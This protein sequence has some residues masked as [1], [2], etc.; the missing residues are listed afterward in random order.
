MAQVAIIGAGMSG[1][2][3][4]KAL[5]DKGF[6]NFTIFD[7]KQPNK[8]PKKGLHYL[9]NPC[10]LPLKAE[11]VHNIVIGAN[12]T[13][14]PY[15]QYANKLRIPH[16]NSVNG[17]KSYTRVYDFN[18]AYGMLLDLFRERIRVEEM[19]RDSVRRLLKYGEYD[20]AVSTIPRDCV[21]SKAQC[22]G[23]EVLT[24]TGR[25]VNWDGE[26]FPQL[27]N[28]VIYNLDEKVSWYRYSRVFGHEV[29]EYGRRPE[30]VADN[31]PTITKIIKDEQGDVMH[32]SDGEVFL[33]G[34]WGRWERGYLAHQTYYDTLEWSHSFIGGPNANYM[35]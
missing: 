16:N 23:K 1:M 33:T 31:C 28:V 8:K 13:T 29:T 12:G 17:L 22:G 4:A 14:P 18:Q 25:P 9:H 32:W 27:K 5:V 2:L 20:R 15:M 11:L 19:N 6:E 21:D 26:L 30:G 24:I 34:R 7:K 35:D 10:G 3:A